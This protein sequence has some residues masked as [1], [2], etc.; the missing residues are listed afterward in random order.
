MLTLDLQ[1]LSLTSEEKHLLEH[2]NLAG[3]IIFSRNFDSLAQFQNLIS[4]IKDINSDI[5]I[6]IDQEGGR[7]Q[8]IK[9][10]LDTFYPAKIFGD[11]YSNAKASN[12]K[13][14][15]TESIK[16]LVYLHYRVLVTQ[17]LCLNIDFSFLP[18]LDVCT[19][20]LMQANLGAIGDRA[21]SHD[22]EVVRV[23]AEEVANA[24]LDAGSFGVFK[25]FPGH[26]NVSLDT[27]NSVTEDDRTWQDLAA[28]ELIP[29]ITLLAKYP[30][31][32]VMV[33][34]VIFPKID[35]EP[36][37]FS[38]F[39]MT[40]ILKKS[41]NCNSLIFSD[42]LNMQAAVAFEKDI[43]IRTRKTLEAG[44]D[45]AILCN[46]FDNRLNILDAATPVTREIGV[47]V[48]SLSQ[49]LIN[50][51]PKQGLEEFKQSDVYKEYLELKNK[52][53]K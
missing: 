22:S 30:Q 25:H 32:P 50:S 21:F 42:D 41:I 40:Q 33:S 15:E 48:K 46:D 5:F 11:L 43:K 16:K 24:I 17:I 4:S 52:F 3:I 45:I 26:G 1:G 8:R 53:I 28:S 35:A 39:W 29:F 38:D 36:I 44:A 20:S 31:F 37:G 19:K 12:S 27:H 2:P 9:A 14:S 51:Q 6:C 47:R 13:V 23:L 34:H 18:V 10:P 49:K 7:V